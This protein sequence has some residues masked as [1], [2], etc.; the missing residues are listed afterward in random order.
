MVW[1]NITGVFRKHKAL[2]VGGAALLAC[3]VAV[4][5]WFVLRG[6][7][8]K[9]EELDAFMRGLFPTM[10]PVPRQT[11][12]PMAPMAPRQTMA[13]VPTAA[14]TAA[15]TARPRQ[16]ERVVAQSRHEQDRAAAKSRFNEQYGD[17]QASDDDR[18]QDRQDRQ[19]RAGRQGR[20]GRGGRQGRQGR[21]YEEPSGETLSR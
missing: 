2:V 20:G 6:S 17:R 7:G 13:P 1:A 11:M 16:E 5:L 21:R 14:P 8:P 4:V 12:A 9:K 3:V 15:P 18:S 19:D 10:A